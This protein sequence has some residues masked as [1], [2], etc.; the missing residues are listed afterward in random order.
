MRRSIMPLFNFGYLVYRCMTLSILDK[1]KK[2]L[3]ASLIKRIEKTNDAVFVFMYYS[4][5]GKRVEI[6]L[7]I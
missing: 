7:S 3:F 5:K 2:T 1:Y 4:N 6:I